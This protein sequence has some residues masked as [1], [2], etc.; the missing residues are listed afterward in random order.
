MQIAKRINSLAQVQNEA[1]LMLG[2]S[3]ALW[4]ARTTIWAISTLHDNLRYVAFKILPFI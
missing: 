4:R 2:G 3:R 1:A